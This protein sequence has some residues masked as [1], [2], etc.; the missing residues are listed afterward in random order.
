MTCWYC[1]PFLLIYQ[2]ELK[3]KRQQVRIETI[4]NILI[5]Y[6]CIMANDS[7][8]WQQ[9]SHTSGCS[10]RAIKKGPGSLTKNAAEC[11]C[12]LATFRKSKRKDRQ[13]RKVIGKMNQMIALRFQADGGHQ[14]SLG[15]LRIV[16]GSQ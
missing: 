2:Y 6:I 1:R 4:K 7:A 15:S 9:T 16:T 12:T 3:E 11:F 13:I 10:T 5:F 14:I 8:M